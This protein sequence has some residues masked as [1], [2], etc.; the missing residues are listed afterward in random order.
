MSS[1]LRLIKLR[2]KALFRKTQ[3]ESSLDREMRIHLEHLV[4]ENIREGMNPTEARYAAEKEFGNIGSY[5]E[6]CRD[7]WGVRILQE[8]FQD[9]RYSLRQLNK[10]RGFAIVSILTLAIGIGAT[11]AIFSIVNSVALRP[12]PYT[13][14][15]R[16]VEIVQPMIYETKEIP[17][18]LETVEEI[19][20]HTTVFESVAA[21][22]WMRAHLTGVEFPVRVTG[23]ALSLN[24]FSTLGVQPLHGR[25]FLPEEGIEGKSNVVIL[26]HAF[27]LSQ[28]NGNK[29]VVNQTIILNNQLHTIIGVMP[30]GFQ[31]T[32][33]QASSP[34][35]FT[36]LVASALVSNPSFL[37]EVIGRLKPTATHEQAQAEIDVLV[38]R[39][40]VANPTLWE[41]LKLRVVS[42]IDHQVGHVRPTLYTLLGAVGFLLLIACVNVAN[43][44]LARASSRQ[45]EVTLRSALGASRTRVVRQLLVESILLAFIGGTLGTLLAYWSMDALLLIAP[46][47]LPRLDEIHLDRFALLFS[48]TVTLLTGIGFGLVPSLRSTK[49]DLTTALKDGSRGAGE[50]RQR[51]RLRNA[52]VVSEV[53]LA[54][55]LLIGAGLLS[56]TYANL[57]K[58]E[59]GYQAET[60]H[61]CRVMLLPE[62]YP[63]DQARVSFADQLLEQLYTKPEIIGAALT[64]GFP[65]LGSLRFRFM[66]EGTSEPDLNRVPL[67]IYSAITPDYFKVIGNHLLNGRWFSD[68]DRE[69]SP[70]VAVIS[71]K[72]AKNLFPNQ[73]PIGKRFS[74]QARH[75]PYLLRE[76]V[77]VVSDIRMHGAAQEPAAGVYVPLRQ[78]STPAHIIPVVRIRENAPNPGPVV[79]AAI[80]AV[81]PGIPVPRVMDSIAKYDASSVASQ[82]FILFLFG[83]FSAVALLLAALGIYGVLSYNVSQRRNEIGVRM[84]L[85]AQRE[86]IVRL[87]L[88]Q[89]SKLVSIG[90]IIGIC[91]ALAGSRLIGSILYEVGPTDLL[92]YSVI[93]IVLAVVAAIACYLPA[94]RATKVDP[95]VAL[96]SE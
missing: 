92:T 52:L 51:S 62:N 28:F 87:V 75:E 31:T 45:R 74:L 82:K 21:A 34:S 25:T 12:L 29:S 57:K 33:G 68:Q 11:T 20:K 91:G 19:R 55:V 66:I 13:E 65:H 61:A 15:G 38:P 40:K 24:Y 63:D 2:L 42:L 67:V 8:V 4:E 35:L 72:V 79:A 84:A 10:A 1:W 89:A 46:T 81:D 23:N 53:A 47:H 90:L 17:P 41:Y 60:L 64:T 6:E 58:V 9:I 7:S 78:H 49:V 50:G 26:N 54:L 3:R 43:L 80:H 69:N 14:P 32:T 48:C 5:K 39:L 71:E 27:W 37:R 95:M 56:R 94:R 85:G 70:L 88:I 30:P 44:L 73:N 83:I 36:P 86:D 77:G 93:T 18:R 59:L 96:R 16:L 22:A 76:I